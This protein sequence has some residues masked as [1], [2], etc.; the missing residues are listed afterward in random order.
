MRMLRTTNLDGAHM[1]LLSAVSLSL[2]LLPALA[3]AQ[4]DEVTYRT[5]LLAGTFSAP[6]IRPY[7]AV[8]LQLPGLTAAE[9]G[10][11]T[12]NLGAP[13]L[14]L[15]GA[16]T[17]CAA[18]SGGHSFIGLS[19]THTR[20]RGG[21]ILSE[22]QGA[23]TGF[24]KMGEVDDDDTTSGWD[25]T[26]FYGV[27]SPEPQNTKVIAFGELKFLSLD[28]PGEKPRE[29]DTWKQPES[30]TRI[31][32]GL[33]YE[34]FNNGAFRIHASDDSSADVDK[35]DTFALEAQAT[36]GLN[37]TLA[38]PGAVIGFDAGTHWGFLRTTFGYTFGPEDSIDGIE[39]VVL[40][41]FHFARHY[42]SPR[43]EV[44]AECFNKAV[45]ARGDASGC[46]K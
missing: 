22:E 40:G 24:I 18:G 36:M 11:T 25:T 19:Q 12:F 46:I 41:G 45:A 31:G 13:Q 33:R 6:D 28:E 21:W 37:G 38:G 9:V 7:A 30:T 2:L 27:M 44:D 29:F 5:E 14:Y 32:A 4:D 3:S 17:F 34:R 26:T 1:R 35:Y 39:L 43:K 23:V 15:E 20:L 42:V 8:G 16:M 10:A